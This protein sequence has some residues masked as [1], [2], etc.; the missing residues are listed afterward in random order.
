MGRVG[1]L[2]YPRARIE[3]HEGLARHSRNKV[4]KTEFP[5]G[6]R[7]EAHG[8][9]RNELPWEIVGRNSQRQGPRGSGERRGAMDGR[10]E[11]A[12]TALQLEMIVD[13]NPE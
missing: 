7:R 13:V 3:S 10:M 12:A 8:F 5:T 6:F 11:M 4:N 2:S 1:A 9:A